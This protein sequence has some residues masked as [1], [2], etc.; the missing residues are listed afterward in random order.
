MGLH[1]RVEEGGR[2]RRRVEHKKSSSSTF[3]DA[4]GALLVFPNNLTS[5]RISK[6]IVQRSS[7]LD[8]TIGSFAG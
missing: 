7:N 3:L 1:L 4:Q 2:R 5:S 6:A 8:K